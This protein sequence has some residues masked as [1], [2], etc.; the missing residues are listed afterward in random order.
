MNKFN[1]TNSQNYVTLL[2]NPSQLFSGTTATTQ[3][4]GCSGNLV[5][6]GTFGLVKPG[7]TF[8]FTAS[9]DDVPITAEIMLLR[10][11]PHVKSLKFN[12]FDNVI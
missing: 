3:R 7:S 12:I 10:Y 9:G 5:N 6:E 4:R 11:H 1:K 8:R 2:E